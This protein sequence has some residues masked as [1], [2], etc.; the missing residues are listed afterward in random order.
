MQRVTLNLS[1]EMYAEL[2]SVAS[3]VHVLGFTPEKWAEE[4][5]ESVLA[6]RRLQHSGVPAM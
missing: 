2:Q 4:A 5:I 1:D 3:S 6:T